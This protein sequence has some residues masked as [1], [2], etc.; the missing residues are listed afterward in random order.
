MEESQEEL[1]QETTELGKSI[2]SDLSDLTL[3]RALREEVLSALEKKSGISEN[4]RK[5]VVSNLEKNQKGPKI[6]N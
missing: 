1:R 3:S 2:F 6:T 4:L 5:R